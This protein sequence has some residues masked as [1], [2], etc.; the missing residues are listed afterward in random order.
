MIN[1]CERS[2]RL[3]IVDVLLLGTKRAY[4]CLT[5]SVGLLSGQ[6]RMQLSVMKA[7]LE[8][9][10][11]VMWRKHMNF[12]ARW[13]F[14]KKPWETPISITEVTQLDA[15]LDDHD[16]L[17][18]GNLQGV[19][20]DLYTWDS[21]IDWITTISYVIVCI[22]HFH[23]NH[24]PRQPKWWRHEQQLTGW[25]KWCWIWIICTTGC[26]NLPFLCTLY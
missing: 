22:Y 13:A 15:M 21:K 20:L 16:G 19:P 23:P 24:V 11:E 14:S 12:R 3:W 25:H 4:P 17:F 8:A 18:G 10:S 5:C 2:W 6:S 26:G 9:R 7:R 1:S